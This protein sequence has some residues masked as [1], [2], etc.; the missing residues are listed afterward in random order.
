VESI[1]DAAIT[2]GIYVVIDWHDH[3]A[4]D[5]LVQARAFFDEM[6][7]VYGAYPNVIFETFNEPT[8]QA[9]STQIKPYHEAVVST[10]RQHTDNLIILGS[11]SWDQEVEEA[12]LDPVSGTHLAYAIHFYAGS[13]SY[14]SSGH[15][16][17]LR[18]KALAALANGV[19]LFA[20]EWGACEYTGDGNLDLNAAGV[21]LDFLAAHRISDANWAISDKAE[22]CAALEPGSSGLGDW[23]AAQLTASGAFIRESIRSA[24]PTVTSPASSTTSSDAG[25]GPTPEPE[26]EPE[27]SC[28]ELEARLEDCVLQGKV[29]ECEDCAFPNAGKPCCSCH[30]GQGSPTTTTTPV[31]VTETTTTRGQCKA[32]CHSNQKSWAKKCKWTGCSGCDPCYRRRLRASSR[33]LV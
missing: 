15:G 27:P 29:F 30:D 31:T 12:S 28:L 10:I 1:V 20:S 25:P 23:T 21:W 14:A 32:W 17:G 2:A 19:P 7:E 24:T 13:A 8:H 22:S 18:Q 11:R 5:H 16:E 3:N 26:P 4:D 6:A 33:F 9:W